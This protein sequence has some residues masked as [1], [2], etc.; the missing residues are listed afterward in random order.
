MSAPAG[1]FDSLARVLGIVARR[2]KGSALVYIISSLQELKIKLDEI[3]KRLKERDDE[4]LTKAVKAYNAGDHEKVMIYASEINEVRKLMKMVHV[5]SLAIERVHERL[6]T[7]DIINDVR[8][9]T[10]VIGLLN[11]LKLRLSDLMP[12]LASTLDQVVQNVNVLVSS[13]QAPQITPNV[14]TKTKEI[15]EIFKEIEKQAEERMKTSLSPIP[16][17]LENLIRNAQTSIAALSTLVDRGVAEAQA[18]SFSPHRPAIVPAPITVSLVNR[19]QE[20]ERRVYEYIV[21]HGGFIDL[22]DCA[23]RFGVTKEEVL[24]AL[25]KLEERGL[26]RIS[27]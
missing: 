10:T 19:E 3:K 27:S 16:T 14:V 23:R 1:V 24:K 9:L 17:Q 13:T 5:A 22:S 11:E 18:T 6:R 15:E 25:R 12:E 8:G 21:M 7:I 20:L 4:L 2:D 26:I